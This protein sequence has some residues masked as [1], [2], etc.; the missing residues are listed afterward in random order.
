[1]PSCCR[2]HGKEWGHY[3]LVTSN[4]VTTPPSSH[5]FVQHLDE[6]HQHF[7]SGFSKDV[8][9]MKRT[10]RARDNSRRL[11]GDEQEVE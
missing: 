3:E 11:E 1:M 10:Q 6:L 5:P 7:T 8:K 4:D 2:S 9:R